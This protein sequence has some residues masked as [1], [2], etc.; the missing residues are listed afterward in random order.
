MYLVKI[1]Y[2][3]CSPFFFSN[4]NELKVMS[5]N[6]LSVVRTFKTSKHS[7]FVSLNLTEITFKPVSEIFSKKFKKSS[8]TNRT[9]SRSI[10]T[11]RHYRKASQTISITATEANPTSLSIKVHLRKSTVR[12]LAYLHGL[13]NSNRNCKNE[14]TKN[15]KK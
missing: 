10:Q 11:S 5:R 9:S 8:R 6:Y 4:M 15:Q 12:K 1:S 7:S 2:P 13:Q 3:S 14:T